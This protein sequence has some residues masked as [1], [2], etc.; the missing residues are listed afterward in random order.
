MAS[1]IRMSAFWRLAVIATIVCGASPGLS[2]DNTNPSY[3]VDVMAGFRFDHHQVDKI[4][5][6]DG[7]TRSESTASDLFDAF[8]FN[9]SVLP[10]IGYDYYFKWGFSVTYDQ[11]RYSSN[12]TLTDRLNSS[13]QLAYGLTMSHHSFKEDAFWDLKTNF[14]LSIDYIYKRYSIQQTVSADKRS[15]RL[16]G[17]RLRY[18]FGV[19]PI[20][21][22][23][24][25]GNSTLFR[26]SQTVPIIPTHSGFSF[27]ISAIGNILLPFIAI[28]FAVLNMEVGIEGE[29]NAVSGEFLDKKISG[30]GHHSMFYFGFNFVYVQLYF[31]FPYGTDAYGNNDNN[32]AGIFYKRSPGVEYILRVNILF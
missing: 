15:D 32:D 8:G 22:L 28:G 20:K 21:V 19:M 29:I 13:Q 24:W 11:M 5:L 9:I 12:E 7:T 26:P 27:F 2:E 17:A 3:G 23:L 4:V 30:S 16:H 10:F 31:G 18:Q 1:E 6:S 25:K 14:R